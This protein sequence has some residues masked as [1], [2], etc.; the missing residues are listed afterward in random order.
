MAVEPRKRRRK[1]KPAVTEISTVRTRTISASGSEREKA[2]P[3]SPVRAWPN[4]AS[5]Q[6]SDTPRSG[7]TS[8]PVGPWNDRMKIDDHRPVEEDDEQREQRRQHV[9][10]PG[11]LAVGRCYRHR[12]SSLRTSTSRK[13][14]A[15]ISSTMMTRITALAAARG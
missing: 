13:I 5:N 7:K 4:S 8:P 6:V 10:G 14:A 12:A 1:A 11:P 3:M 2:P 9:E 15:A